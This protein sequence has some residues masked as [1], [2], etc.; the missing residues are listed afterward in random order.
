MEHISRII[1]DALRGTGKEQVR[2][3]PVVDWEKL[4]KEVCG[5]EAGRFSHAIACENGILKVEVTNSCWLMEI[6]RRKD[7][8][9]KELEQKTGRA[10]KEIR[11]VR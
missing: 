8:L 11:F 7:R 3:Q 4:W 2:R 10:L 1:P 9:K 5:S 6:K